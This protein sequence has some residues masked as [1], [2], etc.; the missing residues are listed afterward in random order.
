MRKVLAAALL[1]GVAT[2]STGQAC[3]PVADKA[4]AAQAQQAE[5][6]KLTAFL[7]AKFEEELLISP[8]R[9]TSLGR[10]D[11][12][13]KLN[14]YSDAW[15]D[16]RLAWRRQTVADLKAHIDRAKLS[17]EGRDNYDIWVLELER[18]E[19]QAKFRRQA[20]VYGFNTPHS[21]LPRFLI[22]SH[23]V[24]E[25]KDMEAY[26]ARLGAV[27][28]ALDQ[29]T[30]RAKAAAGEGVHMPKF[31]YERLIAQSQKQI[32]GQPFA[33]SGPD[34][35]LWADTQ[36]KI[37]GLVDAG[38]A[39]PQQ[40]KSFGDAARKAMLESVKPGYEHILAWARGDVANAPMGKVGA[41]TLPDGAAWYA[42]A[43]K[44]NTTTDMTAEQVHQ[45]GLS[46][47]ARIHGEMDKLATSAGF[48]DAK[49]LVAVRAKRKDLV[50]PETDAGREEYLKIANA[51]LGKAKAKLA[52]FFSV[53]PKYETVVRREPAFSEVP[54]GA[55][56]ASRA[57]PDG[58]R[59]GIVYVHLAS[60]NSLPKPQIPALICHEGIPGHLFQGDMML[61]QTG[62]PTFRTAYGY[63]AF[64]EGWGL[65]S[66]ALC[67]DMRVYEDPLQDFA[68]LELELWRAVRLVD[69]T[70]IHAFGWTE[71]EAVKYA[72]DNAWSDDNFI[73]AEV[74]RFILN[75][76]Q[77]CAYKIGQLTIVRLRDE[78]KKELGDTFDIRAFNDLVIGGGS[79][80]LP[81]LEQRLHA[82]IDARKTRPARG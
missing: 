35:P 17:P 80:P 19:T 26:I 77:A 73:H 62:V 45:L 56:H 14:D 70:G 50:F 4:A 23:R 48:K 66:E 10:K 61:R 52:A 15:Q 69:D 43:L 31:Q 54:G 6:A 5:T 9:A 22:D 2:C 74:R 12:Y 53:M 71:D 38:K 33:E 46:E 25:L 44:F 64:G 24:S 51:Q 7:D 8:Q 39:T 49:D 60:V 78:A 65:Y 1:T 63:A 75:P 20:Y 47:V 57:A 72:K 32:T 68:R 3:H 11:N 76:G 58:S 18:A 81:I 36:K 82:W 67:A 27:G 55:A 37:K 21:D 79:L 16:K 40:A 30:E 42:A 29:A 13:D 28:T 34:A 59:P 41:L